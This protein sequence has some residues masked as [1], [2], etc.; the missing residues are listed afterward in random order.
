MKTIISLN[1]KFFRK[2][3]SNC[4]L[5]RTFY[6][7]IDSTVSKS[8]FSELKQLWI[9]ITI[10]IIIIIIIIKSESYR[11][12]SRLQGTPSINLL[13]LQVNGSI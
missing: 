9:I 12:V 3:A 13:E 6:N 4:Y 11:T 2:R 1:S 8:F 7:Y 5:Q 10:I